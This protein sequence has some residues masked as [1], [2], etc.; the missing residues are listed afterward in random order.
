MRR[1]YN[2]NVARRHLAYRT[3]LLIGR[4]NIG[5]AIGNSLRQ[6]LSHY[7]FAVDRVD[8]QVRAG[9]KDISIP[10]RLHVGLLSMRRWL[11]KFNRQL[12][13]VFSC[14]EPKDWIPRFCA[15]WWFFRR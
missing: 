6:T 7:P 5:I 13:I 9:R 8:D 10:K 14:V 3:K 11:P 15:I 12:K 2:L 4:E 1:G